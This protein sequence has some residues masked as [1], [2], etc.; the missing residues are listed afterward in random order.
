MGAKA[1]IGWTRHDE[2][3]VKFDVYAQHIGSQWIFY[4]RAKRNEQW[5]LIQDPP[6]EDWLKLLD[7][8]QRRSQRRLH[9]PEEEGKIR[10]AIRDRFPEVKM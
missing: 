10:K 6:I 2:E 1:E 4:R 7:S 8:V 3:G 9:R 5:H